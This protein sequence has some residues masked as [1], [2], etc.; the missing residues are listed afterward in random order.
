MAEDTKAEATPVA[1]EKAE[2][3]VPEKFA[4]LVEEIEKM[5]T[6]QFKHRK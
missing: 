6:D 5:Y 1:E 2:V 4:K 3:V